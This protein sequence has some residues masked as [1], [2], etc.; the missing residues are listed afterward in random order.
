LTFPSRRLLEWVLKDDLEQYR[1][2]AF[3]IPHLATELPEPDPAGETFKLPVLRRDDFT[4]VHTGTLLGHRDPRALLKG[5]LDFV[6]DD[7]EKRDRAHL[8]FV[9]GVIGD[10]REHLTR[11]EW[12]QLIGPDNLVCLDQRINYHRAVAIAKSAVSVVILEADGAESPFFPAKLA[13]YLWLRKPILALSPKRSV[14]ADILGPDYQL[15]IAPDDSRAVTTA[16]NTLWAHW[17]AGR[18]SELLPAQSILGSLSE[19]AIVA[20]LE[21]V[22]D[23]SLA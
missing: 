20:K 14:V 11:S 23:H 22:F 21:D 2:K 3:V 9:G 1:S 5:F 7:G 18:L 19:A 12:A 16:L 10:N 13:D 4:I 8:V 17:T 6:K 15:R